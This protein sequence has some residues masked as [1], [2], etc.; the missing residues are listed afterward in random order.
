VGTTSNLKWHSY[1]YG[2]FLNVYTN[3]K[4]FTLVDIFIQGFV[5]RFSAHIYK[6]TRV[7]HNTSSGWQSRAILGQ[8]LEIYSYYIKK[9]KVCWVTI[10]IF[11]VRAKNGSH[12]LV[13][14]WMRRTELKIE[15]NG[16]IA[17]QRIAETPWI[18]SSQWIYSYKL[19]EVAKLCIQQRYT[20][21]CHSYFIMAD[22][23]NRGRALSADAVIWHPF[24]AIRIELGTR[25]QNPRF[26]SQP[27]WPAI[28]NNEVLT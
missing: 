5:T 18:P 9:H 20:D 1:V 17:Y 8:W 4:E 12:T 7:L 13:R 26:M 2:N 27:K 15:D 24:W 3:L 11:T 14:C 10:Y 22:I 21:D 16:S 19:R 28:M 23:H 6:N 25:P